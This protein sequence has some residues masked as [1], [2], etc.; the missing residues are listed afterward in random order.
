M[1]DYLKKIEAILFTTGSFLSLEEISRMCEIGSIGYVQELLEQLKKNYQE[2]NGSL[3]VI[4]EG[5]KWKLALKKEYLSVTEKLLTESEFNKPIQETLAVIAYKQPVL[6]SDI[7][8]VRG[9]TAYDHIKLLK[10]QEF[11]LSEKKGRTRVLRLTSKFYE[12]FD[13]VAEQLKSKLHHEPLQ[14]TQI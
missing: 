7:I 6:Q 13:V 5:D 4:Q 10:E 9:N 14:E 8:K 3:E 12:Y 2:K 11:I 1:E